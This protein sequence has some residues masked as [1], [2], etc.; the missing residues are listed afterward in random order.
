[1]KPSPAE[2][3]SGKRTCARQVKVFLQI[4]PNRLDELEVGHLLPKHPEIAEL[5]IA[6][7]AADDD[8][9]QWKASRAT[10]GVWSIK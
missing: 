10:I 2:T 3:T 9:S 8:P 6:G 1:M 7:L 5:H 4:A